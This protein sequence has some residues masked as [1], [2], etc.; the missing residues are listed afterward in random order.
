M[1]CIRQMSID[2]PEV[3]GGTN[4]VGSA[5]FVWGKE[6]FVTCMSLDRDS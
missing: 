6:N 2:S 3:E 1:R 5:V 4:S